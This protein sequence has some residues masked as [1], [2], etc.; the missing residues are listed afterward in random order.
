M[1]CLLNGSLGESKGA[2]RMM[3][4]EVDEKSRCI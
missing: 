2:R 4:D 1:K 3:D